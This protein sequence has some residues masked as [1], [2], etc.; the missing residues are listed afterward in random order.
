MLHLSI[1]AAPAVVLATVISHL[2]YS[3]SLHTCIYP[4]SFSLTACFLQSTGVILQKSQTK[5]VLPSPSPP[6][7]GVTPGS[8]CSVSA[9]TSLI[10]TQLCSP[11]SLLVL[12]TLGTSLWPLHLP[13]PLCGAASPGL[14]EPLPLTQI[15]SPLPRSEQ[16]PHTP[17]WTHSPPLL[18]T[19]L[20]PLPFPSHPQYLHSG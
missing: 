17:V 9:L 19:P 8:S 18:S 6:V 11:A 4:H 2:D 14:P 20:S 16:S 10:L 5:S 15:C 13:I 12:N 1:P 3:S 7:T